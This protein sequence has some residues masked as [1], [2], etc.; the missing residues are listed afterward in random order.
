MS[1]ADSDTDDDENEQ[2]SPMGF[3]TFEP[4]P[5]WFEDG[6][7]EILAVLREDYN[8]APRHVDEAGVCRGRDAAFRCRELAAHGLLKKLATGMYDVTD[9]GEQLLDGEIEP[10]DL[11]EDGDE[12][13]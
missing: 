1:P 2:A 6:D 8:F 4:G 9:R 10:S 11:P 5:N 12:T 13:R 7:E 3:E